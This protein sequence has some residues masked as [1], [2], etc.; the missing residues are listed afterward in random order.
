MLTQ[1]LRDLWIPEC[2]IQIGR[3]EKVSCIFSNPT[4]EE[5]GLEDQEEED[6]YFLGGVDPS[7]G[8]LR[9]TNDDIRRKNYIY[10]DI[11]IRKSKPDISDEEIKF[12]VDMFYL[13]RLAQSKFK[14]WRYIVF[15]GNGLHLYFFGQKPVEIIDPNHWKLGVKNLVEEMQ[16]IFPEDIIDAACINAARIA[17]LPG[18]Y[19]HKKD[20]PK[21]V[22]IVQFQDVFSN[23]LEA[24]EAAGEAEV[25]RLVSESRGQT[26]SLSSSFPG[27]DDDFKIINAISMQDIVCKVMEWATD[28]KHFYA[29]GSSRKSACFVPA[30]ENYLVHGGCSHIPSTKRGYSAFDFVKTVKEFKNG[31]TFS[32]FRHNFPKYF[33]EAKTAAISLPTD[34][35]SGNISE[36]FHRLSSLQF[37]P[38]TINKDLDPYKIIIRGAVTRIGAMSFTGK[39]SMA[40]FLIHRLIK[41]GYRGLIIS[42]EV[43]AEIVLANLIK[44]EKRKKTI[45]E[46]LSQMPDIAFGL[47]EEFSR[48][49]IFDVKATK[50][51]LQA[52]EEILKKQIQLGLK[53]DFI[54]VDFCQMMLPKE[55]IGDAFANARRYA[56]ESQAIAQTYNIAWICFSQL[57]REGIRDDNEKFG[58]IP[59]ENSSSLYAVADI[60][61]ML[62]RDKSKMTANN[63]M[64]FDVRKHKFLSKIPPTLY[65]NY[66]WEGGTYSLAEIPIEYETYVT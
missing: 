61:I 62:K 64:T 45:W 47:Q 42:T 11:D 16:E 57:N 49:S 38:L 19:N 9:A 63:R 56:F 35:L 48:L 39:S 65:M 3:L 59:F 21:K 13:P 37:D 4:T 54:V 22:E 29:P 53:P 30:G 46:V 50:N 12:S 27:G 14:N 51:S 7:R 23:V 33:P 18:S 26:E 15:T 5:L 8:R 43:P 44:V 20:P 55:G 1:F 36:I 52:V 10:F 31:Q 60:A 58:V 2:I 41:N 17:R 66:D 25:K 24:I 32:W 28:G 34:I 6:L 40:Y